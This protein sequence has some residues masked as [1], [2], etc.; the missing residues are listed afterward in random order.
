MIRPLLSICGDQL[1]ALKE[2]PWVSK[3]GDFQAQN[4]ANDRSIIN[5]LNIGVFEGRRL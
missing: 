3:L 4:T 2:W 1:C 5:P